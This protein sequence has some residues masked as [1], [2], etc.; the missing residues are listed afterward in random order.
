MNV[1]MYAYIHI[2]NYDHHHL[3][4][5]CQFLPRTTN[6]FLLVD[7]VIGKRVSIGSNIFEG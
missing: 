7:S 3:Y 6:F 1:C 2:C 5:L 4:P